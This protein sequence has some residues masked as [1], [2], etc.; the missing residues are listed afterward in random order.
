MKLLPKRSADAR[1][2]A[3]SKSRADEET[4][5]SR[6][7]DEKRRSLAD[8][9]A[10]HDRFVRGMSSSLRSETDALIRRVAE[11]KAE[12]SGLEERRRELRKPLDAEWAEVRSERKSLESA[13]KHAESAGSRLAEEAR[14]SA[15][16]RS[17]AKSAL[18][19]VKVRERE[20]ARACASAQSDREEAR[21]LLSRSR[22]A[23][24][25][26]ESELEERD[27]ITRSRERALEARK[28]DLDGVEAALA[29]KDRALNDRERAINDRYDTL[30]RT[31]SRLKKQDVTI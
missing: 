15:I 6:R 12:A 18:S 2:A 17:E 25:A 4:A 27:S 20:L 10:Q 21:L 23:A 29:A 7:I 1:I 16:D 13:L 24:E 28:S 8:L 11:L 22:E 30:Q 3:Q 31:I 14:R 19:R 5:I 26:K 9:E